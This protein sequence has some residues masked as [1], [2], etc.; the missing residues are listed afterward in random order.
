MVIRKQNGIHN[1]SVGNVCGWVVGFLYGRVMATSGEGKVRGS[2]FLLQPKGTC[3]PGIQ[4]GS[5]PFPEKKFHRWGNKI[6]VEAWA[7]GSK[8]GNERCS[9]KLG[10]EGG[11]QGGKGKIFLPEF[12]RRRK[13]VVF[14]ISPAELAGFPSIQQVL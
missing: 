5:F 7:G 9:G 2:S 10:K 1:N 12:R 6:V 3:S 4:W 13:C 14:S 11:T 8:L